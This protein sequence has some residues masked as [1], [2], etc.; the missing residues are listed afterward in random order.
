[1]KNHE[2]W[3]LLTICVAFTCWS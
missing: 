2:L 3:L 1:M